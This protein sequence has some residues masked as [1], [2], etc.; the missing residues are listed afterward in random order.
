MTTQPLGV[1][2]IT[3]IR[4]SVASR[5]YFATS[6]RERAQA[7]GLSVADWSLQRLLAPTTLIADV[8]MAFDIGGEVVSPARIPKASL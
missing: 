3:P 7:K 6:A 5:V 8:R 1:L 4:A 2:V